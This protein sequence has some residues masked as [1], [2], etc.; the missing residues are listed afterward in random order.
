MWVIILLPCAHYMCPAVS[1]SP[2]LV[3]FMVADSAVAPL[4]VPMVKRHQSFWQKGHEHVAVWQW[5]KS[6]YTYC[7]LFALICWFFIVAL[8]RQTWPHTKR[9]FCQ[10]VWHRFTMTAWNGALSHVF[11]NHTVSFQSVKMGCTFQSWKN[12]GYSAIIRHVMI[13]IKILISL[14]FLQILTNAWIL[15]FMTA[16][17]SVQTLLDHIG[18]VAILDF[19]R[20]VQ[21]VTVS[22][23][24]P[25]WFF[26]HTHMHDNYKS[27]NKVIPSQ[28]VFFESSIRRKNIK[29]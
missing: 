26:T 15:L 3:I 21:P 14:L 7:H 11:S 17:K 18:A 22:A 10:P 16:A 12:D 2:E 19:C 4:H 8:W 13:L 24:A 5:K 9:T 6:A 20:M 28:I 27:N 29:Y 25:R 23:W 1:L